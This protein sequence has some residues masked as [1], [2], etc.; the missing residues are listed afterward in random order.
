VLCDRPA[1]RATKRCSFGVQITPSNPPDLGGATRGLLCPGMAISIAPIQPGVVLAG[2]PSSGR[3]TSGTAAHGTGGLPLGS[4]YFPGQPW[5]RP[6]GPGTQAER[7]SAAGALLNIP[8]QY[9]NCFRPCTSE[10]YRKLSS[11]GT[12]SSSLHIDHDALDRSLG[13]P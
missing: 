12:F 13:V 2:P 11:F 3:A 5:P 6:R 4:S 1:P 10:L 7:R 9:S 8:L